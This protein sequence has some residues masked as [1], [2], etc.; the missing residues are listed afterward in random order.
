MWKTIIYL[1]LSLCYLSAC[2]NSNPG[3]S[4][5]EIPSTPSVNYAAGAEAPIINT[6]QGPSLTALP[7]L[8]PAST[9]QPVSVQYTG[10]QT[11]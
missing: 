8:S 10:K 4:T 3:T 2:T 1:S 9:P 7:P 11:D 6:D 5:S